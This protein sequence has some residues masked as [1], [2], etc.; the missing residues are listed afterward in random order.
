M[1]LPADEQ[2]RVTNPAA[3]DTVEFDE[4]SLE[5]GDTLSSVQVRYEAWGKLSATKDNVVLLCH[6]L[7]GDSHAAKHNKDD[8]P[9][10]WDLVVGPGKFIDTDRWFVVCSNVLGGCSGTT[11]PGQ[12][13]PETGRPMGT[14]FPPITIGDMADVQAKLCDAL[15]IEQL[16]A[17]IGGS[18]GGH[19]ALAWATRHGHR[20]RNCIV[21]A[22]SA[23]LSSQALAFDIVGRNAILQDA[24]FNDG[25]YYDQPR[26]PAV[27][28]A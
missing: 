9:G 14:D 23:R 12:R 19:Q 13:D 24:S 21:V 2:L 20:V 28:L 10:W 17:V 7:T 3:G 4:M 18:M 27:G 25:Q 11:G 8:R 26:K 1:A 16:H 5:S 22:S 6:A 15:G